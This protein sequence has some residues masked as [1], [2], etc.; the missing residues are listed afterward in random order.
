[1]NPFWKHLNFKEKKSVNME[2]YRILWKTPSLF[3]SPLPQA[4]F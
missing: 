4:H 2:F 1:M 3:E